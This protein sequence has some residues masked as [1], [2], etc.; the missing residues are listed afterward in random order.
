MKINLGKNIFIGMMGSFLEA[1]IDIVHLDLDKQILLLDIPKDSWDYTQQTPA[2]IH[3]AESY[4]RRIK[5]MWIEMGIFQ[6]GCT[7]KYKEK[8][9][10]WT[11]EM[12]HENYEKNK[13]RLL[14][15]IGLL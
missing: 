7:V 12:G 1:G 2:N 4:A 3:N 14:E 6:S 13:N 8:D 11:K 10:F 5:E 15:M 9:V